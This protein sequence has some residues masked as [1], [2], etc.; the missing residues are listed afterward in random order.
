MRLLT[1]AP[2][3]FLASFTLC[4]QEDPVRVD[5]GTDT[6]ALTVLASDAESA[7]LA[8]A[9]VTLGGQLQAET[10]PADFSVPPGA[11]LTVS[12]ALAGWSFAP[13]ETTVTLAAGAEDT[14]RFRG[15]TLPVHMVIVEDFTGA[16]C[17]GCPAA[18]TAMEEAIT[19]AMGP[20]YT[21]G[22]HQTYSGYDP[23]FFYNPSVHNQRYSFYS[24]SS[25]PQIIVD[26]DVV[27]DKFNSTAI[28]AAIESRLAAEPQLAMTVTRTQEGGTVTVEAAGTVIGTPGAGPWRLYLVLYET[29]IYYEAENGQN[30]WRH[31]VRH[32]N[33]HTDGL[34]GVPVDLTPGADFGATAVFTPNLGIANADSLRAL[35]F[36]QHDETKT[37]LDA[38]HEP[39]GGR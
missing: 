31:V 30:D 6:A 23:F 28:L 25:T 16:G 4:G 3:L 35:A 36:V 26:G 32:V 19:Q 39:N 27:V 29:Y 10:T 37:I 2:L 34:Q 12:L 13:A 15:E 9:A 24:V 11:P 33:T 22:F 8:G 21:L 5:G 20:V 14:L 38:A 18:G 1:L 7:P 17:D